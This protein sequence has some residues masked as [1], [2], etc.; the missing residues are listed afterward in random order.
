[1]PARNCD[2]QT[3]TR[4][5]RYLYR[6]RYERKGNS[7]FVNRFAV[8]AA[9]R[10]HLD[11]A[12]APDAGSGS[13]Y[14]ERD[15]RERRD[16]RVAGCS[17]YA[18]ADGH[19]ARLGGPYHDAFGSGVP[20]RHRTSGAGKGHALCWKVSGRKRVQK[21]HEKTPYWARLSVISGGCAISSG[22]I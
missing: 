21:F 22:G 6:W 7:R 5:H 9:A 13:R 17:G 16:R 11:R 10:G 1:V 18:N 19:I 14:F 2:R 12:H 4:F 8:H 15:G 3:A 20:T